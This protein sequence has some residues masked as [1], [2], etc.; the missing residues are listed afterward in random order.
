M[1]LISGLQCL[2]CKAIM[3]PTGYNAA[4]LGLTDKAQSG[5]ASELN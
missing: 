1:T 3:T 5:V 4:T 2:H